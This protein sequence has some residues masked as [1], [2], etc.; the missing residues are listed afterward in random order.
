MQI[1][2][3]VEMPIVNMLIQASITFYLGGLQWFPKVGLLASR[4]PYYN[5]FW[6]IILLSSR[7][8]A[9]WLVLLLFDRLPWC[10]YFKA[11][12]DL[13]DIALYHNWVLHHYTF[14]LFPLEQLPPL[15]CSFAWAATCHLIPGHQGYQ[16]GFWILYLASAA[17][18]TLFLCSCLAQHVELSLKGPNKS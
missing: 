10:Q 16:I 7:S 6:M 9:T 3:I 2:T 18:S 8:S 14:L 5:S 17:V 1:L 15:S 13:G 4:A 11:C 12:L